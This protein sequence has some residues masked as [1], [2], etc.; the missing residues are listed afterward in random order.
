MIYIK[1]LISSCL[2]LGFI[3]ILYSITS[4]FN[5]FYIEVHFV[6]NYEVYYI[7]YGLLNKYFFT[8]LNGVVFRTNKISYNYSINKCKGNER[9]CREN[10]IPM[11]NLLYTIFSINLVS[12]IFAF[13]LLIIM[14][15]LTSSLYEKK[16]KLDIYK[17]CF[18]YIIPVYSIIFFILTI[19][20]VIF[21]FIIMSKWYYVEKYKR[22]QIIEYKTKDNRINIINSGYGIS[23][24]L[25]NLL[26]LLEIICIIIILT[27]YIKYRRKNID[28]IYFTNTR[29]NKISI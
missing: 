9:I 3:L 14:V 24:Y 27:D 25:Y 8:F 22:K 19:I 18:K 7:Q 20:K 23:I 4:F 28:A 13:I 2:L 5:M 6:K 21:L 29:Y 15:N 26:Y 16:L 1:F 12:I 17:A 10:I 11:N